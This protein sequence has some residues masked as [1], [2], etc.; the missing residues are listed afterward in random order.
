MIGASDILRLTR[1]GWQLVLKVDVLLVLLLLLGGLA[2]G[3]ASLVRRR[4]RERWEPVELDI[5]LGNVGSVK[6]RPNVEVARI[7]H[8]AWTEL[9]TRK[10]G[11]PFD[12]ENDVILEVYNSWYELFREFRR[13]AK[14]IPAEQIRR[15]PDAQELV[16]VVVRSLNEGLRPHLTRWQARFRRWYA[17]QEIAAP[18]DSPQEIQR[19]YPEYAS[20]LGDLRTINQQMVE[21]AGQ[22]RRLARGRS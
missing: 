8:E 18:Q 10:A 6:I 14:T 4:S 12:E 22:L 9:V 2:V 7:A 19:R 5:S 16:D 1:D 3:I 13:L 21:F 20:L 17:Q 11:L 15:N